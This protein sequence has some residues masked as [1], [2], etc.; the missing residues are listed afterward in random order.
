MIAVLQ[1]LGSFR[2]SNDAL[3]TAAI[4]GSSTSLAFLTSQVGAGSNWH[5]LAGDLNIKSVTLNVESVCQPWTRMLAVA[6]ESSGQPLPDTLYM[7]L[8]YTIWPTKESLIINY[9]LPNPSWFSHDL[10]DIFIAEQHNRLQLHPFYL[11]I[12]KYR[13]SSKSVAHFHLFS[14][15]MKK[16]R[17]CKQLWSK[18]YYL[19]QSNIQISWN[20][21]IHISFR[22][23]FKHIS[24]G[25]ADSALHAAC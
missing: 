5:C 21:N 9:C 16:S 14:I 24:T 19:A 25:L 6:Y 11:L 3:Q 20:M 22:F 12:C 15:K 13:S 4:T 2:C 23:R 8:Q 17:I 7:T 10:W 18:P 1:L